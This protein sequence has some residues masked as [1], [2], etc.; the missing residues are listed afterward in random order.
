MA[1]G[2]YAIGAN[3]SALLVPLSIGAL[4][5]V[6]LPAEGGGPYAESLLSTNVAGVAP[7]RSAAVSTEGNAATGS[8]RSSASLVD[9]DI[10]GLVSVS[11]AHSRCSSA[12]GSAAGSASVGELV[13]A[14][15]PISTVDAG[16][17]TAI[18]LP[19]GRVI[20]NEQRRDG[21]SAVTV[22]AVRVSLDG[23][24][25]SGDVVLAQSRCSS[26]STTASRA[27][28]KRAAA[29]SKRAAAKSKRAAAKRLRRHRA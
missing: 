15:I 28:S 6:S 17:N 27:R 14:G 12:P 9:A 4:P 16:S 7:V 25:A 2:A 1:G 19:V 11:A 24:V 26:G 5:S 18:S 13:V 29:K 21:D 10:A 22:N 20:V 23:L 8:V 3:V